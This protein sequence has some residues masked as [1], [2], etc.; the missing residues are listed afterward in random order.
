MKVKYLAGDLTFG[1]RNSSGLILRTR[2]GTISV[3]KLLRAKVIIRYLIRHLQFIQAQ[4]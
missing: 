4:R 1:D 2:L 3:L